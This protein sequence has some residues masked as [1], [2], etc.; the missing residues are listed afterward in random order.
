MGTSASDLFIDFD[1][2][3][4]RGLRVQIEDGIREAIRSG[5][6]ASGAVV[7]STR[8]LAADLGVTRHVVV[9]AYEQLVAEG[10]LISRQG[11]PTIVNHIPAAR[12]QAAPAETDEA[13]IEVD[14][15]PGRPDLDL[16]P[17]AAWSRAARAAL[18]TLPSADLVN[19]NP[20]GLPILRRELADY[21][22]RVRGVTANPGQIII[23]AGVGHGLDLIVSALLGKGLRRFALEDPGYAGPRDLLGLH[24]IGFD[25]IGVDHD[26]LVVDQ[27]RRSSARAVVV[28]PAHQSPTGVVLSADR[29]RQLVDW[30]HSV[31][32]FVIEDDYDAEFR[33]DRRPIGAVQG[34]APERVIY[35]GAT[36][37]SLASGLRIGWVVV[38][39]DLVEPIIAQRRATDG[40]TST[41]LQATFAAFLGAGDLDRHLRRA[42]P[43]YRQ[44]RDALVSAARQWLPRA[45]LSG[46]SAGLNVLLTFPRPFDERA[47]AER[48]LEAGVRVYPLQDF[49]IARTDD[50]TPGLVL[51]YG[52]VPPAK[53]A[54]GVRRLAAAI[55]RLD[56][57]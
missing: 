35:C 42:R 27:L 2:S 10:Y 26:G 43:I 28:T 45:S 32:G 12:A 15:R 29:R 38:P 17:R 3:R 36:S 16:F 54:R 48:A 34:L 1:R 55:A 21:L 22:A 5:R 23:C 52:A 51:G 30:A 39:P 8:T 49:R 9:D 19:D 44:R 24:R 50:E 25:G 4:Q 20:R 6:L 31:D 14:F 11:A 57:A 18:A 33:Y 47:V 40:A 56:L 37:K 13:A 53:A 41:I 7:P 46:V